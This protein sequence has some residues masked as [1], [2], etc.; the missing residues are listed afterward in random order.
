MIN[1]YSWSKILNNQVL[2]EAQK[3]ARGKYQHNLLIGIENL[4]CF[5]LLKKEQNN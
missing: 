2:I 1:G 4:L 5:L 3:L